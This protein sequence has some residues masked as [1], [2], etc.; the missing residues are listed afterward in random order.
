MGSSS[1][2]LVAEIKTLYGRRH[3]EKLQIQRDMVALRDDHGWT[4][5]KIADATGISQSTVSR[6]LLAHEEGLTQVGKAS[7]LTPVSVQAASDMRVAGRVLADAPMEAIERQIEKLP[8]ERRQRIAAAAGSPYHQA[9]VEREE[10]ERD[11]SVRERSE[12]DAAVHTA[13]APARRLLAFAGSAAIVAGLGVARERLHEII[14]DGELTADAVREIEEAR[15][16]FDAEFQVAC[17][18]VGIEWSR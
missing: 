13:T 6:W 17:G 18:L 4:E 7:R 10:H 16:A 9:R 2:E 14:S 1:S 3:E 15:D 8:P 11:L 12:R 5:Q